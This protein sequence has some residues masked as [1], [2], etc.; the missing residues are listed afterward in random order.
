M[1]Y[2]LGEVLKKIRQS[3][4]YTQKY[5]SE[6]Q[7]SRTTYAKIEACTMQ[8]TVGKFMHILEKLDISYE[9]LK[10]IQNK[11][12]L[13]GKEEIV[14]DFFQV[15]TS[16]ESNRFSALKEKC[17][18]YLKHYDDNVVD[19]IRSICVAQLIIHLENDYTKAHMHASKVW[20]RLS[21]LDDWYTIELKLIN[22]I[23]F[24]FPL[25]T[26]IF[27]A[28]K[29]LNEISKFSFIDKI[30][31]LKP[32]YLLNMALL[33][34]NN[35]QFTEAYHYSLIAIQECNI[36]KRYD[37]I[38][39][40]YARSGIALINLGDRVQ[41]YALIKK[42]LRINSALDQVQMAQAIRKEV[43]QKTDAGSDFQF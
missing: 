36:K 15:S 37:L 4:K 14:H 22:N 29:A 18:R 8:P 28:K 30:N 21:K 25:E 20:E 39:V 26:G 31:E 12:V 42:A 23:F 2:Q 16:V 19:D 35:L 11:Y 10:Y 7:M 13:E 34:M 9:E 17:E 41:G 27:I 38:S 33:M 40:A 1:A 3:K 24:F 6:G 32:A 43:R 5:V